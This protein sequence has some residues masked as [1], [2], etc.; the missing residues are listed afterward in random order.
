M[1]INPVTKM[2]GTIDADKLFESLELVA[3]DD[4]PELLLPLELPLELVPDDV[5]DLGTATLLS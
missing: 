3:V 5:V 4:L 1:V 2:T